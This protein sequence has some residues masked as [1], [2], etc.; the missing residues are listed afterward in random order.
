MFVMIKRHFFNVLHRFK[1]LRNQYTLFSSGYIL[2]YFSILFLVLFIYYLINNTFGYNT[3]RGVIYCV[4]SSVIFYFIFFSFK[5]SNNL[6]I[7]SL[8]KF[9][10]YIVCFILSMFISAYI[11]L[12]LFYTI[13]C[14][15]ADDDVVDTNENNYV[16]NNNNN[17]F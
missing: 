10:I 5:Y 12:N 6:Y 2:K 7:K 3:I 11:D 16:V 14:Y 17:I 9:V 1:N 15:G 13:F 4:I 8:Q